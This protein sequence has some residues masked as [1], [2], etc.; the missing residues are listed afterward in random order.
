MNLQQLIS[1][2]PRPDPLLEQIRNSPSALLILNHLRAVAPDPAGPVPAI[3][4]LT[5]S[6]YRQFA[7]TGERAGYERPYFARRSRLTRAVVELILGDETQRETIHDL[8]WSICEET[9]WVLPAHEGPTPDFGPF[10]PWPDTWPWGTN[11]LLTREPDSIDLFAAETGAGLAETV[12]LLA[13]VLAPEVVQR[14]RQEVD[15]RI[16][17]PYLAYGRNQWWFKTDMNWNGVCN[18]AAG[19]AFVRL[20]Q[21]P[22]RLAEAL[23]LVLEGFEAYIA[24]GFEADGSSLEGIA[25]WNYGLLYYVALAELLRERTAGRIDL[26]AAPR[27]KDIARYPL[28]MALSPD[29]FINFGDAA[30]NAALQPGIIQRLAERTGVADLAALLVPPKQ[31]EPHI[32][33]A[34]LPIVLRDIAWWDG[35]IRPFPAAAQTDFFLPRS[36]MIKLAGQTNQGQPVILAA[37]AGHNDGHHNHTDIGHFIVHAGTESLLCDPGRGLYSRE[38]FRRQRFQNIFCNSLG[39]SV[40]RIGG[41]LQVPGPNFTGGPRYQGDIV[42]HGQAGSTKFVVIHF[43]Q[44]Y[45]LP[46][47]TLARRKLK[48]DAGTGEIWL[49]DK[50][51]FAGEPLE[52]EEAFVTWARVTAEG[53]TARLVGEQNALSLEI[54]EPAGAQFE[55][56]R[57]EEECRLNQRQGVLT[58]LAVT[59]PPGTQN[60]VMRI[61]P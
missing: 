34:K 54:Q 45:G 4:S 10:K 18:G 21:D 28:A 48:L 30:E 38:Y 16:F 61:I 39:H 40:P 23:A 15:R 43:H 37:K 56:T 42:E 31:L 7:H 36:A 24:T 12:Y 29:R 14:V 11:S 57:L 58:R 50:F 17:K 9:S 46:E 6:L 52:I 22:R 49:E 41:H 25:Y 35:Q 32:S 59:L 47:L 53:A 3:P 19:L 2:D 44:V 26:L 8:L 51:A 1:P 60:F 20:E 27:L 5:Y 33:T 13:D 55:V